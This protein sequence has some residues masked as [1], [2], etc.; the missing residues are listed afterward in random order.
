MEVGMKQLPITNYQLSTK[1]LNAC[2]LLALLLER[3]QALL[4][5]Y[6]YNLF[7]LEKTQSQRFI[8]WEN[9]TSTKPESNQSS[10]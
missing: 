6:N 2:D 1:K 9:S 3:S 10:E 8:D 5:T 7:E 4:S